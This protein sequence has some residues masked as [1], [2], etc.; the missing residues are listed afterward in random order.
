MKTKQQLGPRE[1]AVLKI[2]K[3]RY[4]TL[5]GLSKRTGYPE[6]SVSCALRILRANG[7]SVIKSWEKDAKCHLY[8]VDSTTLK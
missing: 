1:R 8:Y 6:S 4:S 5:R 7:Y 3:N 2:A